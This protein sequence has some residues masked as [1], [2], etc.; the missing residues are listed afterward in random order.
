MI[1]DSGTENTGET[2]AASATVPSKEPAAP[3]RYRYGN[4]AASS[5]PK[6]VETIGPNSQPQEDVEHELPL[7]PVLVNPSTSATSGA[8]TEESSKPIFS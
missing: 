2:K 3:I 6:L 5:G 8:D 7:L 1:P 4:E